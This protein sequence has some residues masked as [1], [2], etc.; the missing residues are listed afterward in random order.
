MNKI[1]K[2]PMFIRFFL[3]LSI[4]SKPALIRL[5]TYIRITRLALYSS[6]ALSAVTVSLEKIEWSKNQGK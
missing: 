4:L 5:G 1:Y 3:I 2:T 6:S